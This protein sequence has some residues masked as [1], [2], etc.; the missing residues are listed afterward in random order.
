LSPRVGLQPKIWL[1]GTRVTPL[2]S[3]WFL[4]EPPFTKLSEISHRL[5]S[6]YTDRFGQGVVE[7]IKDSNNV[8]RTSLQAS[9]AYLQ[10]TYLEPYFEK[11][12]RR[13]RPTYFERCH[14]IKRFMYATPFTRHGK[15]HGDLQDQYKRRTILSTQHSFPYVKTRIRVVEREQK[16]LQPIQ[17]AIEDIEKKTRE[18]SAAIAQNPPDAKMLQMVLQ[19]CIGTTDIVLNE[20]GVPIDKLQNKLKICFHDFSKKCAD[21]LVLN[22]QLILPDQLAYQSELQKN[23]AEFTRRMAPIMGGAP[24]TNDHKELVTQAERAVAVAAEIGPVTSV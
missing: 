24:R 15:A 8:V 13:R 5:E 20:Y 21:A 6:F 2:I 7:V 9:K 17:V 3:Y 14:K 1:V 18:L 11:W 23:Y 12:E 4:K 19:G 10:I 16:V 22:K